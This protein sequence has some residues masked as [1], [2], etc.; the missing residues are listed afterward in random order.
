LNG[1]AVAQ[2]LRPAN[3]VTAAADVLAGFAIAGLEPR[4]ALPWLLLSTA[5]LYAGGVALNDFFDRDVDRFERPERPI[6]SGRVTA[7]AAAVL[8]GTLLAAGVL[9]GARATPAAGAIAAATAAAVLLYDAWGKRHALTAPINMGLCRGLNL[10][11]GMAAAPAALA[12]WWPLALI[13]FGYIAAVTAVSRG[14]VH[15][16]RRGVAGAALLTLCVVV[17]ALAVVAWTAGRQSIAGLLLAA[18]LG[19][20]VLPAFWRAWVSPAP[21]PIRAAVTRGILSL[22]L[23]D[24]VLGAAFAGPLYTL[25]VLATGLIAG[26]L[27]RLFPVT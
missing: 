19:W 27:A 4:R 13:P 6:P 1:H 24:G 10:V 12:V 15:G 3:V 7:R 16:G 20:R 25:I 17:I 21:E 23:V 9:S 22:V 14:E 26:R 5:C 18:L 11:L 8:G 2:L